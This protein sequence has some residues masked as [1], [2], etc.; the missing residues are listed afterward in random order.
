MTVSY[1]IENGQACLIANSKTTKRLWTQTRLRYNSQTQQRVNE[2]TAIRIKRHTLKQ[3]NAEYRKRSNATTGMTMVGVIENGQARFVANS[4]TTK[5]LWTQTR[6]ICNPQTLKQYNEAT[7]KH[8]ER[9]R[10]AQN[11]T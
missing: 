6:L 3:L 8:I 7:C 10:Y 1:V 4:E 9:F 2:E 5:R 11:K